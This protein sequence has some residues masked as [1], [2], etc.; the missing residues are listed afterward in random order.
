MPS[1]YGFFEDVKILE[2]WANCLKWIICLGPRDTVSTAL[3]KIYTGANQETGSALVQETEIT[4]K[5]VL[6]DFA[7]QMDLGYRQLWAF[8]MRYYRELSKKPSGN[9]LLARPM[10]MVDTAKLREMADLA[11]RLGFESFEII[12]LK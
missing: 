12:D 7:Y 9:N 2:A 6:A 8:A 5:P 1:L 10:A 4:F 11:N 3:K